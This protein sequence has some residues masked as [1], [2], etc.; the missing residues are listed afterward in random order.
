MI[1]PFEEIEQNDVTEDSALEKERGSTGSSSSLEIG[2]ARMAPVQQLLVRTIYRRRPDCTALRI[3]PEALQGPLW[4]TFL[5]TEKYPWITSTK[6][7]KEET[8]S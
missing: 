4:P 2:R 6:G 8:G 7:V 3:F 5:A 1:S